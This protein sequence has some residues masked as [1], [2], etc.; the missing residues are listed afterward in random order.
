MGRGASN[1][2]KGPTK[3]TPHINPVDQGASLKLASPHTKG[4]ETDASDV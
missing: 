4:E 2:P 3:L 1:P